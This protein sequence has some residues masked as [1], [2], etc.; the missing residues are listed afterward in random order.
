MNAAVKAAQDAGETIRTLAEITSEVAQ[1][2]TQISASAGQQSTGMTQIN[3]AM[4]NINQV[5]QQQLVAT[6]QTEQ[7]AQ[8]LTAL[9][10]RLKQLVSG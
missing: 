1:S 8:T 6:R 4:R 9:G 5:T 3:Q 2:V 10:N 7:T